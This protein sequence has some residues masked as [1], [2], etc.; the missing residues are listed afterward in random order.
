MKHPQPSDWA[1]CV[2][3]LV[4]DRQSKAMR[5]HALRCVSCRRTR[6]TL[7]RVTALGREEAG[8]TPSEA[9]VRRAIAAFVSAVAPS[10]SGAWSRLASVL[11][12]DSWQ[13]T[14]L[15]GVRSFS[16]G[17]ST[18]SGT[19]AA[20]GRLHVGA[21]QD[22]HVTYRAGAWEVDLR[23]EAHAGHV[24]F[25]TGQLADTTDERAHV[26]GSRVSMLA[27]R[28]TIARTTMNARGEF[29]LDCRTW[30]EHPQLTIAMPTRRT[31]LKIP[32]PS[33]SATVPVRPRRSKQR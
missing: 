15:A 19:G 22:R 25:V 4:D 5:A 13:T 16:S 31:H 24:H 20:V 1:D 14:A 10:R 6:D 26:D 28:R 21:R 27:G 7:S 2:R 18:R 12:F 23:V 8:N 11:I 30:P 33:P 32:L 17:F 9:V 3:G 29:Q